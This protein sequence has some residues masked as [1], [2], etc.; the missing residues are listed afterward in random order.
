MKPPPLARVA[1]FAILLLV[2]SFCAAPGLL[3]AIVFNDIEIVRGLGL[4]FA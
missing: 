1:R 3:I 2:A 4:L